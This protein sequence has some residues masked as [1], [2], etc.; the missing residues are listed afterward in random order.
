MKLNKK[1]WTL[2]IE[3]FYLLIFV[4]CLVIA[5]IGIIRLGLYLNK[6]AKY[7]DYPSLE[8]K[9]V[10]SAKNYVNDKLEVDDYELIGSNTLK[11]KGYLTDL[12]DGENNQC[13]GYVEV[14]NSNRYK[15]YI[16]CIYYETLGYEMEKDF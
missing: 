16:K 10:E 7:F 2:Q 8:N 1:G 11:N 12:V 3:V 9:I 6:D 15:G 4:V 5:I 14:Y 13:S